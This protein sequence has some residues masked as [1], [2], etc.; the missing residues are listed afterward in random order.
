MNTQPDQDKAKKH[1]NIPKQSMVH[2]NGNVGT[3]NQSY[4]TETN[5]TQEQGPF[6]K[7]METQSQ[8]LSVNAPS[9]VTTWLI[10]WNSH[11]YDCGLIAEQQTMQT[12]ARAQGGN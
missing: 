5:G 11:K 9:V 2:G 4:Q 10:A 7:S 8:P 12:S 6:Q 3:G 1:D